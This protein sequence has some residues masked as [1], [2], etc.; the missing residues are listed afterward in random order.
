M[1]GAREDSDLDGLVLESEEEGGQ[2]NEEKVGS[3]YVE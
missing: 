2:T 1:T 3:N